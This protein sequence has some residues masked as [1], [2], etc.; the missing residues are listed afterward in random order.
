MVHYKTPDLDR[1]FHALADP[2]RR[3]IL[4][5]LSESEE[6]T[7]SEIAAPFAM[8]LPALLKHVAV[9]EDAGLVAREKRGRSVHCRLLADPMKA[10]MDWLQTYERFWTDRLDALVSY[11]EDPQ[12]TPTPQSPSAPRSPSSAG[13]KRRRSAS[14]RRGPKRRT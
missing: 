3:A 1:T 10:A 12:W 4:A 6:A 11:L 8:S 7:A 2:T 9:L 5:R 13:S 14:S